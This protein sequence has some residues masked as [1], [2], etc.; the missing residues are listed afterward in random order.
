MCWQRTYVHHC[1]TC[2]TK[3]AVKHAKAPCYA[4]ECGYTCTSKPEPAVIEVTEE[5]PKCASAQKAEE[6]CQRT[7]Y[8]MEPLNLTTDQQP[9][10]QVLKGAFREEDKIKKRETFKAKAAANKAE[11]RER[12]K[13]ALQ[14]PKGEKKPGK[15]KEEEEEL[16]PAPMLITMRHQHYP[17][18]TSDTDT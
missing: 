4:A 6:T 1:Y 9:R 5:C 2:N 3:F 17:Y 11:A 16:I 14:N 12:A 10:M 15:S 18:T 8:Q 13:Q 7:V